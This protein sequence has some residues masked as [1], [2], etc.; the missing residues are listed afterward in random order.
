MNAR[1]RVILNPTAGTDTAAAHADTINRRLRTRYDT[2]EIVLTTAG[3]D[4]TRA[5]HRAVE[6]GCTHLFVGGGDGTLNEAINGVALVDGALA[7]TT[8]GLVPL[9]TGNDFAAALGIPVDVEEALTA[10]LDA[11]ARL[12]DL[13]EVNGR[14]FV[15]ISGGGFFA[16]V[17]ESVTPQMKTVAGRL[18]YLLGGAQVLMEFEP[19]HGR[20]RADTERSGFETTLYAFAVCNSRMFGGG[21]LIAPHAVV[22]DGLLDL[23]VIEAMSTLEFATLLRSVS[24]GTHVEDPRVRYLRAATLTLDFDTPVTINTDGEVLVA[25][26]CEYRVR[27]GATRFFAG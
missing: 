15:N 14:L 18:A 6:D 3:G 22:D 19:V 13:G 7:R 8:F 24:Q 23:C 10:L 2:L 21:N 11:P 5:A 27:P 12:V 16:E 20:V 26:R 17:S 4:A 1:A 25:S 9:G